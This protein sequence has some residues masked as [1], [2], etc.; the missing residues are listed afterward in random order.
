[1]NT[2]IAFGTAWALALIMLAT[3][4]FFYPALPEVMISHWTAEGIPDGSMP[5]L[6]GIVM[7]P[8]ILAFTL[9]VLA[10]IPH[11]DPLRS[12]IA[13]FRK[14]YDIFVLLLAGMLT[15]VQLAVLAINL[16]ADFNISSV[17]LP[18]VGVLFF[19]LG[20]FL[21]ETRRNWFIGI[22][23]PWTISSDEVWRRTHALGGW[24][25]K[26]LGLLA[27]LTMLVPGYIVPVFI[28]PLVVAVLG[29][30]VYSYVVYR[31]LD[32]R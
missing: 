2:R 18:L 28:A 1:M 5:R 12:N 19:C 24:L 21:P 20:S 9:S 7:M 30:V 32:A 8:L 13:E 29:L 26:L 23:T 16:G 15:F 22:R 3:G 31:E 27:I 6:W 14:Q 11:I 10:T 17:I 4:L 25:F